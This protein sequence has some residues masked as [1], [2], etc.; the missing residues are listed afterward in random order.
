VNHVDE[1]RE[2]NAGLPVLDLVESGVN[3]ETAMGV[4]GRG[5]SA[6]GE[7]SFNQH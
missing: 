5:A 6:E 2:T 3:R 4:P 7:H 1:Y